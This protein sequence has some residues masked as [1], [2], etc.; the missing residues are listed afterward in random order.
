MSKLLVFGSGPTPWEGS[1]R[2]E[3]AR[4]RAWQIARALTRAKHEVL[5]VALRGDP[6]FQAVHTEHE[7]VTVWS[8]PEH[9]C[10]E[11][12]ERVERQIRAF[13]PDGVIGVG[14]EPA[15]VAVNFAADLP[16]WADLE[17]EPM[18]AVQARAARAGGDW[19]IN[20]AYRRHVPVLL[21]SDVLSVRTCAHRVALV[22]QL[23][24]VGRLLPQN[25]AYEFVQVV[26]DAIDEGTLE[27]LQ[28][29]ERRL[30]RPG[31]PFY[32]LWSGGFHTWADPDLLFEAVEMLMAETDHFRFIVL[33]AAGPDDDPTTFT[34]FAQLVGDSPF[35]HRY[36]VP[37]WVDRAS[38]LERYAHADAAVF[39]ERFGY[40][41]MFGTRAR[42]VEWLAAGLPI[43]CTDLHEAAHPLR[44]EGIAA[45]VPLGAA[46]QLRDAI[47]RLVDDPEDALSRGLRGRRYAR[48]RCV[49]A[50]AMR[51]MLAWASEPFRAPALE[52]RIELDRFPGPLRRHAANLRTQLANGGVGPTLKAARRFAMRR[53]MNSAARA[54]DRLGQAPGGAPE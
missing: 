6:T 10:H 2:P 1:S 22:G 14:L 52:A 51:P 41:G 20:E 48:E 19:M 36:D 49:S 39:V 21:R 31:D 26:P 29:I 8:V 18:T 53:L 16:F 42:I 33:G 25:D 11:R 32:L 44:D 15:A 17:R 34:R 35:R 38:V 12:P 40:G 9:D 46:L 54:V 50:A 24:M 3:P 7:T 5:L 45:A 23:G 47:R 30:R 43:V 4:L 13:R 37:G 28:R 27:E